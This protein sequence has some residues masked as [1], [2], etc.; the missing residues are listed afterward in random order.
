[1][2]ITLTNVYGK[3]VYQNTIDLQKGI[4]KHTLPVHHLEP[5]QYLLQL[6][7]AGQLYNRKF[8]KTK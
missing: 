2:E 8:V 5:G 4:N 7:G 3:K 1:M 6:K